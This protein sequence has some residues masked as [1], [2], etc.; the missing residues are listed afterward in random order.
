M[1]KNY[2]NNQ[3]LIVNCSQIYETVTYIDTL[4]D[5]FEPFP[6]FWMHDPHLHIFRNVFVPL[7][8]KTL[9]N[10][11]YWRRNFLTPSGLSIDRF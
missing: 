8:P 7:L 9:N 11:Q 5:S 2:E 6:K 1:D 10:D 4:I 3:H